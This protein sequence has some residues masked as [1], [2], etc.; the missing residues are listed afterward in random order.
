MEAGTMAPIRPPGPSGQSE[1]FLG[2]FVPAWVHAGIRARADALGQTTAE[3]C[4][5]LLARLAKN[6]G[7]GSFSPEAWIR[8]RGAVE[9]R[10]D[11][12]RSLYG[13]GVSLPGEAEHAKAMRGE[14]DKLAGD[15]V[16][17]AA[18]LGREPK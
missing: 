13:S 11:F 17:L 1:V 18:H 3:F 16:A 14:A 5:P 10:I 9:D 8:L 2:L 7:A 12:L 4:R 6:G 15:L